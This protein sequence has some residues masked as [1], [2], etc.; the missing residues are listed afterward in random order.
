M[1]KPPKRKYKYRRYRSGSDFIKKT[2]KLH[3]D[4]LI[5]L[6][7]YSLRPDGLRESLSAT[8]DRIAKE[9]RERSTRNSLGVQLPQ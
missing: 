3:P 4:T 9:H 5:Y 2:V 1:S 6:N 7:D 8:M